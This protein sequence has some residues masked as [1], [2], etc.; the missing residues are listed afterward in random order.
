MKRC[1]SRATLLITRTVAGTATN[2]ARERLLLE[3]DLE[4]EH[5]G[6]HYNRNADEHWTSSDTKPV[7]LLRQED[8]ED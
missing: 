8:G 5:T 1:R 7:T 2:I 3:C 6:S 4:A